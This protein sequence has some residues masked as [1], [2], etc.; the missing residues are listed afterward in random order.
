MRSALNVSA[1]LPSRVPLVRSPRHCT[2]DLSSLERDGGGSSEFR[3]SSPL[4]PLFA[5]TATE[6]SSP[7]LSRWVQLIVN[8][9]F[10]IVCLCFLKETR[11]S[12]ILTKR[13]KRLRKETGDNRYRGIGELEQESY[14]QVLS[15]SCTKA[16]KLLIHEPVVLFFSLWISFAWGIIF[17]F[18]SAIPLTFEGEHGF[19]VGVSGLAYVPVS[20]SRPTF[21]LHL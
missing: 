13:A 3:L 1:D 10:L 19:A 21:R 12:V 8:G 6:P 17:L 14:T 5:P 15:E 9:A 16:V 2:L 18:F 4:I 11:G 20:P 7:A